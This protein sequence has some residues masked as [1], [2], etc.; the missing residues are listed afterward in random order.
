MSFS[1]STYIVKKNKVVCMA[2][3]WLAFGF[4]YI[5][6][7]NILFPTVQSKIAHKFPQNKNSNSVSRGGISFRITV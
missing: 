3:F 7:V 2:L 4:E 6:I 5:I 1:D